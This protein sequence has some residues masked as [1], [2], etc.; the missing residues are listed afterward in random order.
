VGSITKYQGVATQCTPSNPNETNIWNQRL[1]ALEGMMVQIVAVVTKN[2]NPQVASEVIIK[3]K[4]PLGA[5]NFSYKE[6]K[7]SRS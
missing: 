3:K 1:N 7:V 4:T 5:I 2:N 6:N